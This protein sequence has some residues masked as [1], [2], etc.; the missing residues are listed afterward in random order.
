M[1]RLLFSALALSIALLCFSQDVWE[2]A[3]LS[4]KD[5]DLSGQLNIQRKINSI[6]VKNTTPIRYL[7]KA[8]NLSNTEEYSILS[9]NYPSIGLDTYELG[10]AFELSF[11]VEN[12]TITKEGPGLPYFPDSRCTRLYFWIIDL[13]YTTVG[14]R[15]ETKKIYIIRTT[16]NPYHEYGYDLIKRDFLYPPYKDGV[17]SIRK[18]EISY[19]SSICDVFISGEIAASIADIKS[20]NQIRISV[21]GDTYLKISNTSC[22]VMTKYGQA[23][24]YIQR[25]TEYIN[26]NALLASQEMTT[27]I[28]NGLCCYETYLLRGIAYYLQGYYKSAIEDLTTAIDYSS[29]NKEKAYYYRGMSKLA[30]DDDSGISDLRNGG[31]DGIV[32]LRENN[33][34]DY[35]PGQKRKKA[36][37]TTK[38]N[39][40]TQTKKPVLKK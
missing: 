24:P 19:N 10:H 31:Q 15:R 13:I 16:G 37:V 23:L 39:A 8:Q 17:P 3:N 38:R 28:N 4:D 27:A 26:S 36:T 7:D 1:K 18:I 2:M 30:L 9:N 32:F 29:N 11:E 40:P 22:K 35:V 5:W 12:R 21:G 6:F 25:A 34:M 20:I 14:D 33:L